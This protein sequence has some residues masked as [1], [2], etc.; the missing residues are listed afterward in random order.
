MVLQNQNT[1]AKKISNDF[2]NRSYKETYLAEVLPVV[3]AARHAMRNTKNWMKEKKVKTSPIFW[4]GS[5]RVFPQPLGVVAVI[6]PWNYPLQL[7]LIPAINAL[8]A[9]NRVLIKPSEKTPE[10]STFLKKCVSDNF[11]SSVL[12][13]VEGDFKVAESISSCSQISHIFFTGSIKVGRMVARSAGKNLTPTTLELGGKSPAYISLSANLQTAAKSIV[14]GKTMNSG[15]TC[16][17]PDYLLVHE[18]HKDKFLKLFLEELSNLYLNSKDHKDFT[19]LINQCETQRIN[20]LVKD[21]VS[22]GGVIHECSLPKKNPEIAN[23]IKLLLN[24]NENMLVMHEEIFGPLLPIIFVDSVEEAIKYVNFRDTPLALYLFGNNS[25]EHKMWAKQTKSGGI[26]VNDCLLHVAQNN[27]PFGGVG[28]SGYG[29][30]HGI[31]GFENFS[32][33]K[34]IFVQSKINA[35]SLF[36]PPYGKIFNKFAKY[37]VF[38]V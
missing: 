8:S 22:K 15:Q 14:S 1:F 27:L 24:C 5:S 9:G 3:S 21:A 23:P 16:V 29:H 13:V 34:S 18:N 2:G 32:K 10:F 37:L 30:Y 33:Q 19:F 4:F 25:K 7:S 36:K 20:K 11:E 35:T 38:W 26:T 12:Q 31:W 28:K 6:S 17:A